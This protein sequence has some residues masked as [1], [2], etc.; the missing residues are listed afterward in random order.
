MIKDDDSITIEWHIDDVHSESKYVLTDED[1]REVL[2]RVKNRHDCNVGIN[3]DVLRYHTDDV[4]K[5]INAPL[6]QVVDDEDD[7]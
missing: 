4:A 2:N 7:D 5:E 1:C 3:W 6:K